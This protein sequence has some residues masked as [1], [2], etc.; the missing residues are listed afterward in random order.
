MK[1]LKHTF[2]VS[3]LSLNGKKEEIVEEHF[4]CSFALTHAAHR[5]F[6]ES[7]GK[8]LL[9]TFSKSKEQI[10]EKLLEPKFII[11]LA[12]ACYYTNQNGVLNQNDVTFNEFLESEVINSLTLDI[13]FISSL[14]EM[15][16]HAL[17]KEKA[18]KSKGKCNSG[19]KRQDIV[20]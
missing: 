12:S 10:N 11:G 18:K 19:K 1:T 17:P 3:K 8:S 6:E 15:V 9:G 13:E 16:G 4:T 14:F 5:L 7:Y 2:T 20:K